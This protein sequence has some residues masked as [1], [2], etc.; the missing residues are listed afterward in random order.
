MDDIGRKQCSLLSYGPI[1]YEVAPEPLP[2]A[3]YLVLKSSAENYSIVSTNPLVPSSRWVYSFE[4]PPH[5]ASIE[6]N[7]EMPML[8]L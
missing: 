1:F 3:L 5:E 6:V 7:T 4:A 8:P 2:W